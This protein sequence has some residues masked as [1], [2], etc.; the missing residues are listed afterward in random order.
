M[1]LDDFIG[2]GEHFDDNTIFSWHRL[3]HFNME[4]ADNILPCTQILQIIQSLGFSHPGMQA[5]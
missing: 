1:V 2:G 4:S 3:V 5:P